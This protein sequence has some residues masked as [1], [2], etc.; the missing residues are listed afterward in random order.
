MVLSYRRSSGTRARVSRAVYPVGQSFG[1]LSIFPNEMFQS[2]L[3][4][5]KSDGVHQL[6]EYVGDDK[7]DK[8]T[9]KCN[10]CHTEGLEVCGATLGCKSICWRV[11]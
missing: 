9:S 5:E 3:H 6:A 8:V 2:L 7:S 4:I 11:Q 1:D 10:G